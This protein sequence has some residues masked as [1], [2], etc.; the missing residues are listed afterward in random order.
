MALKFVPLS[1]PLKRRLETAAITTWIILYPL[2]VGIFV[3]LAT[4]R[5]ILP[6]ALAYLIY[7]YLDPAPEMGGRKSMWFRELAFWRYVGNY[8]PVK[9]IKTTELDPSKN[10][11][12]GYH[13]HGIISMGAWVNF[14][15]EANHFSKMFI[16]IDLKL[17]TL[18]LNFKA[19]F[20]REVLLNLGICSVSRR[21]CDNIL[22]SKPGNSIMIV[23]GGA[24]EAAL[25]RPG[26][27]ELAVKS[28]LGFIKVA[29]RTGSSL[30]PVFSFGENDLWEQAPNPK[31]SKLRKFQDTVRKFT[32]VSPTVVYG[33]GIFNYEV[34]ILPFRRPVVSVVGNPID[35]P[36]I[37]H[38]STEELRF[39]Q[40]K[41]LNELQRIYDCYKD[42]YLPDRKADLVFVE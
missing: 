4:Y 39:Y 15:T 27:N 17:L 38:P 29:L 33:R 2:L 28:R 34:G 31:G 20:V 40:A 9:L 23:V 8:F 10:Y 25:A 24:K 7:V 26:I 1:V 12:F 30:V 41:Y 35:V 37:I 21:S 13:P 42:E 11:V 5:D 32:S 14:A 36:K 18:S 19:P 22:T 6:S 16:G 3:V